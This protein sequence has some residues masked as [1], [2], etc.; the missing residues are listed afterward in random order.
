MVVALQKMVAEG[1]RLPAER[2]LS[3]T[4][5]ANRYVVRQAIQSLRDE[6]V[7]ALPRRPRPAVWRHDHVVQNTSPPELW[8]MR[9]A[10]EPRLVWLA[11]LNGTPGELA[12]I[13]ELHEAAD[14]D[15][16]ERDL[17]VAF[18]R[19]IAAASHNRLAAYLVGRLTEITLDPG[20]LIRQPPLTRETGHRHHG[21]IV[22]ALLKRQP[23]VAEKVMI[24]HL[25]AISMWA[26]GLNVTEKP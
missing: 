24:T 18:H 10:I 26:R 20:F 7:L 5:G 3:E 12:Q 25:R 23:A 6:G 2:R 17:D 22:T 14:P 16:F 19:A 8:E 15:R 21:D 9:L 4:L 11:G 13:R 1:A